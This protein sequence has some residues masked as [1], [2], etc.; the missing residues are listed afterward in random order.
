[1]MLRQIAKLGVALMLAAGLSACGKN[2][3][4]TL[5]ELRIG[6]DGPEEFGIVPSKPLQTPENYS[7]L[8]VPTRGGSNRADLTPEADAVAALGGDGNRVAVRSTG[9]SRGDGALVNYASRRG[10]SPAIRQTL[11]AEDLEF[12]K[13]KSLFSWSIKREDKYYDAY[14]SMAIDPYY[15]LRLYR[16]A[17]A[18]T[19]AATPREFE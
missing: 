1:M 18:R 4:I 3:D 16:K 11:A 2:R 14:R 7:Q 13:R 5:H 10:V 17:G 15:V 19:P 8:P 9:V 6:G 12:R